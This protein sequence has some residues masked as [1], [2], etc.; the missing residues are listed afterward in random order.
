MK[1]FKDKKALQKRLERGLA[2]DGH[3]WIKVGGKVYKLVEYGDCTGGNYV[4]FQNKRTT[5]IID[6]RYQVPCF[7]WR[8]GARVQTAYY[9]FHSLDVYTNGELYRY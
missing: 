4:L 8:D 6:I 5:D 7:Q 3:D 2:W 9:R 1:T